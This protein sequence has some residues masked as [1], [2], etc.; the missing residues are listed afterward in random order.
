MRKVQVVGGYYRIKVG[1]RE[2]KV[3]ASDLK[4]ISKRRKA[5]RPPLP[6]YEDHEEI[7][8]DMERKESE[9]TEET[10]EVIF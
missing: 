3:Y 6:A 5:A 10:E 1:Q 2:Y 8:P 7:I 4:M 9:L